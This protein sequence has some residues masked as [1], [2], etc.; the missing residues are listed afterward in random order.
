MLKTILIATLAAASIAAA[1]A[2]QQ[3]C[4]AYYPLG[5]T[6]PAG[7]ARGL[8]TWNNGA[9]VAPSQKVDEMD[10]YQRTFFDKKPAPAPIPHYGIPR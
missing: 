10:V 9:A 2:Q 5:E 1:N 8:G 4:K 7:C 3:P 6:V